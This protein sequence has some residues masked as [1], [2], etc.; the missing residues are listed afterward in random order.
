MECREGAH[1][2][3]RGERWH[4]ALALTGRRERTRYGLT[5][6]LALVLMVALVLALLVLKLVPLV[7]QKSLRVLQLALLLLKLALPMLHLAM[8]MLMLA[9]LA[10]R[11]LMLALLLGLVL[12]LVLKM[13]RM[14]ILILRMQLVRLL[15]LQVRLLK[16][17]TITVHLWWRRRMQGDL[18]WRRWRKCD[19][20]ECTLWLLVL[21]R[22]GRLLRERMVERVPERHWYVHVNAQVV[23]RCGVHLLLMMHVRVP[24]VDGLLRRRDGKL[25]WVA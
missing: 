15:K 19:T 16:L 2:A 17:V 22:E 23:R 14:L 6:K 7:L 10:L 18:K 12:V 20:R 3:L 4:M 25:R 21:V 8:C 9:L 11:L 5:R 13:V 24:T 1:R